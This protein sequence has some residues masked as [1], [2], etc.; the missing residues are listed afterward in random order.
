MINSYEKLI[1]NIE[2]FSKRASQELDVVMPTFIQITEKKIDSTLRLR[3]YELKATATLPSGDRYI[4]LPQRFLQMRRLRITT[5]P[6]YDLIEDNPAHM[7]LV[8]AAGR[9]RRFAVTSRIEFDRPAAGDWPL[10]MDYFSSIQPLSVDNPYNPVLLKFPNL[11]L[12]GCLAELYR[13]ARDE[14]MATY[15]DSVF[16]GMIEEAKNTDRRG[17]YGPAPTMTTRGSKP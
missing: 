6:G 4:V 14:E 17:R 2:S 1:Q 12:F 3:E 7:K 16:S 15:Y 8:L 5:S 11:Y 10:E 9:P 13:W